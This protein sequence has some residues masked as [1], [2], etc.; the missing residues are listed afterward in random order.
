[1]TAHNTDKTGLYTMY[2]SWKFVCLCFRISF[3]F[4]AMQKITSSYYSCKLGIVLDMRLI[5]H[6]YNI[7]NIWKHGISQNE[8]TTVLIQIWFT[9]GLCWIWFCPTTQLSVSFLWPSVRYF[10]HKFFVLHFIVRPSKNFHKVFP[11]LRM[12]TTTRTSIACPS[13][14]INIYLWTVHTNKTE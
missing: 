5:Y 11:K 10:I 2:W 8:L 3:L 4:H 7:Q 12:S 1:M 6:K 9:T 14:Y 13:V